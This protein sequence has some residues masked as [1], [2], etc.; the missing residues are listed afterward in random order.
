MWEQRYGF[1]A[2]ERTGSGYRRYRGDDVE[3]LRRVA[4]LPPSRPVDPRVDRA[5]PRDGRGVRPSLVVR[6]RRGHGQRRAAP[7]AAQAHADRAE[8]RDRARDARPRRG[9]AAV[10]GLPARGVLPRGRAALPAAGPSVRRGLR[11]R[12]LPRGAPRAPRPRRRSRSH[13]TT[14]WA[15]SGRSS[16]TPPASPSACWPGSSPA[17]PSPASPATS[18]GASRRSG[19][20]IP[21]P[22]GARPRWARG[23]SVAPSR[24]PSSGSS[25]LLA[26][27]PLA[28]EQPAPALTALTNRVVGYLEPRG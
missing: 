27:R 23:S 20:S 22:R 4:G 10:R 3:A 6:G 19:P 12:R 7:G 8:P 5:R 15:T 16:S 18:I 1:P 17:R 24:R 21:R 14:R 25:E 9:A 26:S 2:P 13:P 11:V 28:L